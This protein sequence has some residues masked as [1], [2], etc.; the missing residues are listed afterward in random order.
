[1]SQ[2]SCVSGELH[3]E[4]DNSH[5]RN[6]VILSFLKN[7]IGFKELRDLEKRLQQ[8]P[9]TEEEYGR[10]NEMGEGILILRKSDAR[11]ILRINKFFK[12]KLILD[13]NCKQKIKEYRE[14]ETNFET[15]LEEGRKIKEKS[16]AEFEDFQVPEFN[17]GKKLESYQLKPVKHANTVI[18]SANF[19]VPGGGKTWMALATYFTAKAE[20]ISP[21]VNNLLVIC[22]LSAFQVWEEEYEI[23]TGKDPKK[24]IIRITKQHLERGIIPGLPQHFEIMLINYDKIGDRRFNA[25][26][27]RLLDQNNIFVILQMV[28]MLNLH[29]QI[30]PL[31][32]FQH[33]Q[34]LKVFQ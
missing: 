3:L 18:N 10:V 25:A 26:L 5:K 34:L 14:T 32:N 9:H 29:L 19:T 31:L 15:L 7:T 4:L 16:D 20:G 33:I 11:T 28:K 27:Q 2:L 8:K 21:I 24:N 12:D 23:I 22:P 17:S 6:R 30:L 13:E 1:M